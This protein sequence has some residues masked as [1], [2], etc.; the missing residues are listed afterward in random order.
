MVGR[1]DRRGNLYP[2]KQRPEQKIDAVVAL[3]M[4]VGRA[5]AEDANEGDMTD[6][7]RDPLIA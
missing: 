1:A 6:L 3:V 7:L 5:M 2:A 4:A